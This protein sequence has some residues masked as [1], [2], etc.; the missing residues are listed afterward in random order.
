L[1]SS[2]C[3]GTSQEQS[4]IAGQAQKEITHNEALQAI[5]ALLS[6]C[7]E[8]PPRTVPPPAPVIG[9]CY[10]V[11]TS[12]AGVWTG[13]AQHLAAYTGGGW[14]FIPPTEG[15]TAFVRSS[16][17]MATYQAGGWEIGTL[18]GSRVVIAGEQVVGPREAAIA[19]PSGGSVIDVQAREAVAQILAAMREHGLIS[20]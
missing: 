5:D 20:S 10:L 17:A 18:K 4:R 15:M 1:T 9:A 14:R 8:E 11:D 16:S 19:A 7:V 12:P 13:Y 3:L 2:R 6:A